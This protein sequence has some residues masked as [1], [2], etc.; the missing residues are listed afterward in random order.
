[1]RRWVSV[2]I[3]QLIVLAVLV[4]MPVT[5]IA[6]EDQA[7]DDAI[8]NALRILAQRQ[9]PNGSWA[10]D[11][12]G[13]STAATSLAVMAF[14]A[15]GHVPGEG[16]YGEVIDRGV[17]FVLD[18]QKQT[19][20]LIDLHGHGPMYDH[21][22]STL[23][24][25]EV[26]GM[27]K[28]E[29]ATRTKTA[30]EKA[31]KVILV[32]QRVRKQAREYGGWRYQHTSQDSD[33]SVTGWQLLALR[34]AKDIGCDVPAENIDL[35]VGYVKRCYNGRG[36]GYQ[37]GNGATSSLTPAGILALQLCDHHQDQEVANGI[38]FMQRQPLRF[39][40]PW[41]FYGVYYNAISSYKYGG[42]EWEKTKA[43]VFQ[44]LLAN[45]Q[46]LG[47]WKARNPNE[48]G[49]GEIYATSMAVLALTVEYGYLPIYQR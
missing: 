13:E 12:T 20:M 2:R 29:Q 39:D 44:E 23:M 42:P 48:A 21:G 35:A 30:L 28:K 49:Q 38:E 25:S 15:A 16:P 17:T 4:G 31:V 18:R 7:V 11:A 36:F 46:P 26:I 6:V 34:A 32:A 33:L 37:P 3:R 1:M 43:Q 19:G 47:T 24:L 14:L 27:M 41:F 45:Q 5:A 10:I 9:K 22:I 8:V 40:D